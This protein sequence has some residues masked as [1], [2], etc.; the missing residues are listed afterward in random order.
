MKKAGMCF[1]FFRNYADGFEMERLLRW[2]E[3]AMGRLRDG[4]TEGFCA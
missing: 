2:G 1:A 4:E 3:W